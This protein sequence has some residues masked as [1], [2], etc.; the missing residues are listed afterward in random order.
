MKVMSFLL[1]ELRIGFVS[2][3]VMTPGSEI[4]LLPKVPTQTGLTLLFWLCQWLYGNKSATRE[5]VT[6]LGT[7]KNKI[8][9]SSAAFMAC[10]S[11]PQL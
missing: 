1:I 3:I 7:A 11:S 10:A 4:E 6:V 5:R 9:L 8:S 2:G